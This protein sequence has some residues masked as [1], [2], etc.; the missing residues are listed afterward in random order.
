MSRNVSP[1]FDVTSKVFKEHNNL[2]YFWYVEDKHAILKNVC[3]KTQVLKTIKKVDVMGYQAII[4]THNYD[5]HED[6]CEAFWLQS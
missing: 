3:L 5:K 2:L 6:K 4:W 1:T